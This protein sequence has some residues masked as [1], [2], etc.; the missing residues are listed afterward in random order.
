MGRLDEFQKHGRTVDKSMESKVG[1]LVIFHI[2]VDRMVVKD[3]GRL[4]KGYREETTRGERD[5]G[6]A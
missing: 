2:S 5:L 3:I 4:L 1:C 6:K